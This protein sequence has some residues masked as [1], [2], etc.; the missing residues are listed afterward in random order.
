MSKERRKE[1]TAIS[2]RVIREFLDSQS[3]NTKVTYES[4]FKRVLD[5]D[6]TTGKEMLENV[7]EWSRKIMTF[8]QWLKT[9]RYSDASI[10]TTTGMLR[11]FFAYYRCPLDLSK[12]DKRKLGSK[13]EREHEDYSFSQSDI[14]KMFE[15]GDL[16]E[17]YVLVCGVS[18]GLRSEDFAKLTFGKYRLALETNEKENEER[19]KQGLEPLHTPIKLG[20][21]NTSKEHVLAYPFISSDALPIISVLLESHKDARDSDLVYTSR[22]T[23]LSE[24]LQRVFKKSGLDSHGQHVR[25]HSLRKYLFD[26]LVSVSSTTKASQIIGHKISGEVSPY[27]GTNS[28]RE[29]YE[30]AQSSILVSNGNGETKK[31][32]E[33]LDN[34]VESLVTKLFEKEKIIEEQNKQIEELKA[35]QAQQEQE[36]KSTMSKMDAR[37][38]ALETIERQKPEKVKFEG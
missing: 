33:K 15:I 21:V 26:R 12:A 20:T 31:K 1:H 34:A 23:E 14:K 29:V 19:K 27:I 13:G 16:E 17:K 22:K 11:G 18:F 37:L 25:F 5:F 10:E 24:V 32:V 30:K 2:D 38:T 28:L 4:S 7:N 3:A 9:Q 36:H 8:K 35:K 6:K